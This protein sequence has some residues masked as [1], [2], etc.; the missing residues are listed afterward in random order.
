M[1]YYLIDYENTK[2]EGLKGVENLGE[3]DTVCIFYSENADTLTFDI[4]RRL[5]ESRAKLELI[6]VEVG[7]KNALDFQ[8]VSQLGYL[9]GT[10]A[11]THFYIVS[12]D[13]GFQNAALFWKERKVPVAVVADVS[14]RDKRKEKEELR[15]KVAEAIGNKEAAPAI[16]E[17]IQRYKT[18]QGI[19]NALMKMYPSK[20]NKQAS[21][22]YKAIKTIIRDK[23]G[24]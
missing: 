1:S 14:G 7:T 6:K 10:K 8:L 21:E 12:N 23:K 9:I 20:D 13:N 2:K 24:K 5:N 16:A 17:I 18:K 11:D 4:Y 15:Q 3:E 19:N 22:Y